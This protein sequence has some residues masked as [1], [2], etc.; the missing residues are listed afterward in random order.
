MLGVARAMETLRHDMG[1]TLFFEHP[2]V[3]EN[4][5][6]PTRHEMIRVLDPPISDGIAQ[7][8]IGAQ[9]IELENPMLEP[10]RDVELTGAHLIGLGIPRD[11]GL[12]ASPTCGRANANYLRD[13]VARMTGSPD[14][15]D[16]SQ[17]SAVD[18]ARQL[19]S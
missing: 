4:H 11:H 18:Q 12:G 15:S 16:D 9:A 5:P 7:F 6:R 14:V 13:R 17:S 10:A 1:A 19:D 2:G 3:R 8:L